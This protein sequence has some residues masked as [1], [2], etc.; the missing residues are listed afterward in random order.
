MAPFQYTFEPV[1]E[2]RGKSETDYIITDDLE[3]LLEAD[4]CSRDSVGI[5]SDHRALFVR[6]EC[7]IVTKTRKHPVFGEIQRAC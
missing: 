5:G 3:T 1:S 2:K 6:T 7:D 4:I